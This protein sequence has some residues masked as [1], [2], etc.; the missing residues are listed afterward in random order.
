MI[1]VPCCGE[2]D[3]LILGAGEGSTPG[4]LLYCG[5]II[6]CFLGWKSSNVSC[7]LCED[8]M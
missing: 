2:L 4:L 8:M 3:L 1:S 6:V 5:D 7:Y